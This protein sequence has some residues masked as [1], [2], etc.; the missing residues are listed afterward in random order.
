MGSEM[1][2]RDRNNIEKT[3]AIVGRKGEVKITKPRTDI[4]TEAKNLRM[5]DR[6][7]TRSVPAATTEVTPRTYRDALLGDLESPGKTAQGPKRIYQK[8]PSEKRTEAFPTRSGRL[9]KPPVRL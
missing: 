8:K 4:E 3:R 5:T 1:C 7:E 2:I 9:S 6:P